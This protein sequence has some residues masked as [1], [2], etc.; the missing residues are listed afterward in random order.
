MSLK[1]Y[2]FRFA[3]FEK[4]ITKASRK[5]TR[6][7]KT[8]RCAIGGGIERSKTFHKLSHT[9]RA[10]PSNILMS[11]IAWHQP[12]L[13]QNVL[14]MR[15]EILVGNF[16]RWPMAAGLA[17]SVSLENGATRPWKIPT[18]HQKK[19]SLRNVNSHANCHAIKNLPC[20]VLHCVNGHIN[21]MI[22]SFLILAM[23]PEKCTFYM[24]QWFPIIYRSHTFPI[25]WKHSSLET[26]LNIRQLW[27]KHLMLAV[28][29]D[30]DRTCAPGPAISP[31]VMS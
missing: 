26:N 2:K 21:C 4:E 29:Q 3:A 31:R 18:I 27:L 14:S 6:T 30:S 15:F 13:L 16:F 22:A 11:T 10:R 19:E 12:P 9:L 28:N 7:F 8:S 20:R 5:I 24:D 23:G 17:V 1:W 25:H